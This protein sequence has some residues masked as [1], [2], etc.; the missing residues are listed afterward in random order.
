MMRVHGQNKK[1]NHKH[2]GIG[3]SLNILTNGGIVG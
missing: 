2:I 1:Y 3:D